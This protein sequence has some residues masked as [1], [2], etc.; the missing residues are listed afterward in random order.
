MIERRNFLLGISGVIGTTIIGANINSSPNGEVTNVETPNAIETTESFTVTVE[1]RNSTATVIEV[2]GDA[3][4]I[5]LS[6]DEAIENLGN[7]I[8]FIDIEGGNSTYNITVNVENGEVGEE[9]MI[10]AWVNDEK[11]SNAEDVSKKTVNINENTG[12]EIDPPTDTQKVLVTENANGDVTISKTVRLHNGCAEI[13]KGVT[14]NNGTTAWFDSID[15]S[16]GM[17]MCTMAISH[18][19]GT[20]QINSNEVKPGDEITIRDKEIKGVGKYTVTGDEETSV[21]TLTK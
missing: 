21:I 8:R 20:V 2:T 3:E 14:H 4:S 6:N 16:D 12:E 5:T 18:E 7:Q 9:I 19:T 15:T 10:A 11:K 1:T 13:D 17:T